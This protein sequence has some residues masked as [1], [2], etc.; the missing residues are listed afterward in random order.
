MKVFSISS[1][2]KDQIYNALIIGMSPEDAYLYAQL[3]AEEMIFVT[4][5]DE[6]SAWVQKT[7]KQLEYSLLSDMREGARKQ[8]S[9]GRT[10]ATQWLLE[11]L[12]TRYSQKAQ[13]NMGTINLVINKD[14]DV[15][16][17][18]SIISGE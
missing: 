9:N 5:D 7:Q 1:E 8:I 2:K 13:P 17:I 10:D 4:E 15:S 16:D 6:M 3:S 14:E 12:F 11:K 18:E